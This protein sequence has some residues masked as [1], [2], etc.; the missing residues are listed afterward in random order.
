MQVSPIFESG[1]CF[2]ELSNEMQGIFTF[3]EGVFSWMKEKE[4]IHGRIQ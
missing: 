4:L 3:L 2:M 1:A